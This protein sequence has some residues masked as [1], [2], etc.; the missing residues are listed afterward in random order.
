MHD[1]GAVE[2]GERV[3]RVAVRFARV[4]HDGLAELGREL[5]A[6]RRRA[7]AAGRAARSRGS[8]RDRSPRRRRRARGR[9]AR[10]ARRSASSSWS[11]AWCGSMPSAAKTSSCRSA[12]SSAARHESMPGADGD[13]PVDAGCARPA[14]ER[15]R[16]G[17][18]TRRGARGC[19]SRR[20][21]RSCIRASSSA[22]TCS[23][24]SF[25][26]SGRG[27]R[28]SLAWLRARSAPSCRPSV[29]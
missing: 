16:D 6:A 14:D 13:D 5:R 17:R 26:K 9:A 8:S 28:S 21:G 22:T 25:V 19:R 2:A 27:S 10:A 3:G 24:S 4:D 12:S 20:R 11:A 23:G 1:D 15:G 29:S 18:R 7:S